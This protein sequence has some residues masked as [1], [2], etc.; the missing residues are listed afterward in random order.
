M[1]LPKQIPLADV[2][3]L[4]FR[5]DEE[6]EI[7]AR[8]IKARELVAGF[9]PEELANKNQ[10][11]LPGMTALDIEGI[12]LPEI[13]L[14]TVTRRLSFS[15]ITST[16]PDIEQEARDGAT[17]PKET[18][19]T[20]DPEEEAVT[21]GDPETDIFL[22]RLYDWNNVA[23]LQKELHRAVERDG[24]AFVLLQYQPFDIYHRDP[25]IVGR[26]ALYIHE[27]FTDTQ[28]FWKTFNGDGSGCKA[29]YRN[30]DPNQPLEM[31]S[32]R[33]IDE[34]YN[35]DT[36][37]FEAFQR[38]VL[39]VNEQGH[40]E[41]QDD[42]LPARIEKYMLN[43]A[44]EWEEFQDADDE[45]WPLWWTDSGE[46]GGNSMP[47]PA[48]HFR[49]ENMTPGHKTI[50]GL[51]A[52]LD[53]TF[54]S[55][56]T[57]LVMTGQQMIKVFG[58]HPTTDGKPLADDMSNAL[59]VGPRQIIGTERKG[60]RDAD[61]DVIPPGDIN[62]ILAGMDKISIY[63]AF[64]LGLPVAN[65]M[66]SKSVASDET[67]RQGDTEL[68]SKV[69]DLMTLLDPEWTAVFRIA[70][71]MQ[72]VFGAGQGELNEMIP[73]RIIW[74]I[75]ERREPE[76]QLLEADGMR[77]AGMPEVEILQ[78]VYGVDEMT[79]RRFLE[80]D[81][82][83]SERG[84]GPETKPAVYQAKAQAQAQLEIIEASPDTQNAGGTTG[85]GTGANT[86]TN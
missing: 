41:S 12:N 36:L 31:I 14:K 73:L 28:T 46:E 62:P 44:G 34:I 22:K 4:A 7:Q 59:T 42:Y 29:H 74:D 75:A 67:L 17:D 72:N 76:Y 8:V 1:I 38:M 63:A 48:I 3:F 45:N 58:F 70:R 21:T 53:Q 13:A 77:K 64:V 47:I 39:Y 86:E 57:G 40:P 49:N 82:A 50:W 20:G 83:E 23:V 35:P 10:G 80:E 26:P 11:F 16:P 54:V 18:A 55:L 33:W 51:Q 30:G 78:R 25:T 69:N 19:T 24:E 15:Q 27:R 5:E 2:A 37:R 85:N 9:F 56:L 71:K 66:F 84:I 81:A 61:A 60:P 52:A 68:I 32:H 6:K 43:D 79:A 65:F